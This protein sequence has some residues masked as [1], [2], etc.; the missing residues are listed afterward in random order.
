MLLHV[1][2]LCSQF[3]PPPYLRLHIQPTIQH[4]LLS[5]STFHNLA[6]SVSNIRSR[7]EEPKSN[8]R[9]LSALMQSL[10]LNAKHHQPTAFMQLLSEASLDKA[11]RD[12]L[13]KLD[14]VQA[15][16]LVDAI[17]SVSTPMLLLRSGRYA[18][19][20]LDIRSTRAQRHHLSP[21]SIPPGHAFRQHIYAPDIPVRS[22]C[23]HRLHP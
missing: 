4:L 12:A 11:C 2:S 19:H 8:C 13:L 5:K 22:G 6:K 23:G 9:R 16:A 20:I 10:V 17:Q 15:Q 7:A 21:C 3:I 18:Q 1:N 14:D